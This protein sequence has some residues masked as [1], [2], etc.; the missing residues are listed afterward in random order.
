MGDGEPEHI[1]TPLAGRPAHRWGTWY[2]ARYRAES[3]VTGLCL[4]GPRGGSQGVYRLREAGL[5]L[6]RAASAHS[7]WQGSSQHSLADD[8]STVLT[9]CLSQSDGKESYVCFSTDTDRTGKQA[10]AMVGSSFCSRNRKQRTFWYSF[11]VI[12]IPRKMFLGQYNNCC[13]LTSVV[14]LP[15]FY[16]TQGSLSPSLCPWVESCTSPK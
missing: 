3:E 15:G 16:P 1:C 10:V 5:R 9:S 12:N 2:K 8:T 14:R 6:L 7:H 4:A 11:S 13:K